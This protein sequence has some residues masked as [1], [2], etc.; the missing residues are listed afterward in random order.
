[1][2][3]AEDARLAAEFPAEAEAFKKLE[4]TDVLIELDRCKK[5]NELA[6]RAYAEVAAVRE[7]V[8]KKLQQGIQSRDLDVLHRVALE[9]LGM[10]R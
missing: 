5:L 3:V 9:V 8:I 6:K 2:E 4:E 1:M 10:I 7:E